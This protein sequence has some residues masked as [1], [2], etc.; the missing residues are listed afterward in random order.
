[1]MRIK[2]IISILG[3]KKYVKYKCEMKYVDS[4]GCRYT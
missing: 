2:Q 3:K 1:M 4:F